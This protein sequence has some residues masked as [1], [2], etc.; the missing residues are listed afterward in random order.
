MQS[1]GTSVVYDACQFLSVLEDHREVFVVCML[2]ISRAVG[3]TRSHLITLRVELD[4]HADNCVVGK[5]ALLMHEH[6]NVVMVHGFDPLQLPQH[7]KVVDAA[8]RYTC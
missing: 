2:D 8:I 6:L 7:A 3:S 5:N 4:Y 1:E